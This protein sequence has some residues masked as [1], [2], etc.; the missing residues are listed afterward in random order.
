MTENNEQSMPALHVSEP[1]T[2]IVTSIPQQQVLPQPVA[3]TISVAPVGQHIPI[4]MQTTS[5]QLVNLVL[6]TINNQIY[7]MIQLIT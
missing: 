2:Q 3:A 6:P 4:P 7:Y 1:T 5:H